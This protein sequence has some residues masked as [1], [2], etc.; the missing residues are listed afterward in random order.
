MPDMDNTLNPRGMRGD[1]R[2]L[3]AG[4]PVPSGLYSYF[5]AAFVAVGETAAVSV[6]LGTP[7]RARPQAK[8][9]TTYTVCLAR[10]LLTK[11]E[12]R[13]G[14]KRGPLDPRPLRSYERLRK[15]LS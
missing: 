15:G 13:R 14:P 3:V 2:G 9:H 1:V 11:R 6:L 10:H 7:V 4:R 12:A 5:P 8:G